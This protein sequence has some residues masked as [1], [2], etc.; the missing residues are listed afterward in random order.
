MTEAISRLWTTDNIG[1]MHQFLVLALE[2][3]PQ[4]VSK[5]TPDH[6]NAV[7]WALYGR[8]SPRFKNRIGIIICSPH[9]DR[10]RSQSK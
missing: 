9:T 7:T 4:S 3:L 8:C 2:K 6:E 5:I 10:V 1:L